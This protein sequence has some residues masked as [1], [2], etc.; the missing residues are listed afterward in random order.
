[1]KNQFTV[2]CEFVV[3]MYGN[4][5]G[6][7]E[8]VRSYFGSEAIC[9]MFGCPVSVVIADELIRLEFKRLG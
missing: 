1:M 3:K 9:Q 7:V 4:S 2:V 6:S 8:K 5:A